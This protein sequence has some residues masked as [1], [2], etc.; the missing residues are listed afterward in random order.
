MKICTK[1]VM[2]SSDPNIIFDE[3]GIS[4]YYYNYINKILPSWDTSS[5]GKEDL[6]K[7]YNL[8]TAVVI[9][10]IYESSSLVIY[11]SFSLKKN[12]IASSIPPFIE[13]K[14]K[15][16]LFFFNHNNQSSL[17]KVLFPDII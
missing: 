9:P 14:N 8:S 15:F 5:K 7:I 1:T 10:S 13:L 4:D 12:V 6:L 17:K 3:N 11:E 2:D 16:N